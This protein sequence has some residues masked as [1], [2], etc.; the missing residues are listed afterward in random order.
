MH[1]KPLESTRIFDLSCFKL[2]AFLETLIL[3]FPTSMSY[4]RRLK[5]KRPNTTLQITKIY[6]ILI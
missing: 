4:Q 2:S 6:F 3:S 1:K 5:L